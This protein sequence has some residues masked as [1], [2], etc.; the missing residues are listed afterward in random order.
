MSKYLWISVCLNW[1]KSNRICQFF[2]KFL[3]MF[4]SNHKALQMGYLFLDF[5]SSGLQIIRFCWSMHISHYLATHSVRDGT[6]SCEQLNIILPPIKV[7]PLEA[8]TLWPARMWL[9]QFSVFVGFMPSQ[10]RL[11]STFR[12]MVVL[13]AVFVDR[14]VWYTCW[15]L[16]RWFLE[17]RPSRLHLRDF[18]LSPEGM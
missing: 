4:W 10:G 1:W 5:L 9:T 3:S 16:L 11:S 15:F 17:Y 8:M 13:S 12:C 7:S 2:F 14:L 6:P 18:Q